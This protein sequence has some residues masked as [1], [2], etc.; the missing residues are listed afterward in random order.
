VPPKVDIRQGSNDT[1]PL[2]SPS[3]SEYVQIDQDGY[4]KIATVEGSQQLKI[5]SSHHIDP[6]T[7]SHSNQA[8]FEIRDPNSTPTLN[9]EKILRNDVKHESVSQ[10]LTLRHK[11]YEKRIERPNKSHRYFIPADDL[12]R[13]LTPD[14]V[15]KQLQRCGVSDEVRHRSAELIS[16]S[17]AKLFAILVYLK[18]GHLIFDF[19]A[20]SIDDDH[21]PFIRS[22]NNAKAG[23]YKLCSR[24]S[25]GQLIKSMAS[26]DHELVDDFGR[27][28]WCMLAP[29]FEYNDAIEHLELHDNCV[30]PWLED[31]ERSDRAMEGGYGSVWKIAIHPAHQRVR[32]NSNQMVSFAPFRRNQGVTVLSLRRDLLHSNDFILPMKKASSQKLLC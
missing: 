21:L 24:K 10:E 20:E 3:S 9:P 2:P 13:L 29:I 14:S 16:K 15:S 31:E 6:E 8:A 11:L 7:Q 5:P 4:P 12:E 22:D 30:L 23:N 27:D 32:S 17:A 18:H 28:Q 26:W 25:P 19:L 1:T